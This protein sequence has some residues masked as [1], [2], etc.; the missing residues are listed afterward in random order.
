MMASA[1]AGKGATP[2][3]PATRMCRSRVASS[4]KGLC[5][6]G[7]GCRCVWPGAQFAHEARALALDLVEDGDAVLVDALE[8]HGP[9]QEGI[10]AP[11]APRPC[12]TDRPAPRG[13]WL[14]RMQHEAV[15]ALGHL[16]VQCD[17][18][19]TYVGHGV[20]PVNRSSSANCWRRRLRLTRTRSA[21]TSPTPS[22]AQRSSFGARMICWS[23]PKRST[24]RVD[25]LGAEAVGTRSGR[26]SRAGDSDRCRWRAGFVP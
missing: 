10:V 15:V 7:P 23:V 5:R 13:R 14:R 20:S 22:T 18:A 6:G 25:D 19:F 2:M 21:S 24:R 1:S 4:G 26:G 12:R 16:L 3:P 8:A 9:P 11:P 17:F